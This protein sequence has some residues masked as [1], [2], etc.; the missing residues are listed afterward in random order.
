[1]CQEVLEIVQK[2]D[3][4]DVETKLA[5][6]CAPLITGIKI[7]N[8][9]IV[10]AAEEESVY[11]ILRKTGIAFFRLAEMEDKVTFLLFRRSQLDAYLKDSDVQNILMENGYKDLSLRGILHTFANRYRTYVN[12]GTG[13]PHEMGLLLGYP[14]EDVMGFIAH[15]GKNY[16]YSGYWKVYR[17][18]PEKQRLFKEYE[19]AQKHVVFL[20]AK[21]YGIRPI[22]N[23]WP[24]SVTG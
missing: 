20:L 22:I 19:N 7:S 14:V 24:R 5:L 11:Y 4:K 8:L 9:F 18:V 16:L 2:M 15:N 10:S 3:I 23:E 13:F 6:Q 1:M 17:D 12:E 21:G